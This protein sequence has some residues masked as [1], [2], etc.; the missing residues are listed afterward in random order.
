MLYY[1]VHNRYQPVILI[2]S[3]NCQNVYLLWVCYWYMYNFHAVINVILMRSTELNQHGILL[4]NTRFFKTN[5][6]KHKCQSFTIFSTACISNKTWFRTSTLNSGVTR[7]TCAVVRFPGLTASP[8]IL[9]RITLTRLKTYEQ[10]NT[11]VQSFRRFYKIR[12]HVHQ[13]NW[14]PKMQST[15]NSRTYIYF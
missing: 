8:F 13:N 14:H 15:S 6:K 3:W 4:L 5:R 12:E 9:T 11:P 7:C 2:F 10:C 1:K